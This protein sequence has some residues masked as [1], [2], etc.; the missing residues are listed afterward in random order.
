M[1]TKFQRYSFSRFKISA[2]YFV[3][4]RVLQGFVYFFVTLFMLRVMS[5]S[6]YGAYM[7]LLGFIE[8]M[9][10]LTSF[11]LFE[12]IRRYLPE[13][14]EKGSKKELSSFYVKIIITR[15]FVLSILGVIIYIAWF[16]ICDWLNYT[17]EHRRLYVFAI[18]YI[19]I[20]LMFRFIVETLECL[21]EQK[22]SQIIRILFPLGQLACLVAIYI[23]S[24]SLTF[25]D[26]VKIS[27]LIV[28]LCLIISLIY[29]KKQI[30][31]QDQIGNVNINYSEV[32]M[33]AWHISGANI[34]QTFASFGLMR[35]IVSNQLGLEVAGVFGFL[36]Q[37]SNIVSRYLP[38]NFLI[39]VIRPMLVS[40]YTINRDLNLLNHGV[41][42][43]W[44]SNIIIVS[45]YLLIT[46]IIG[47][48][49]IRTLSDGQISGAG[50]IL[51]L[52]FFLLFTTS[53]RQLIEMSLQILGRT[54]EIRSLSFLLLLMPVFVWIGTG[55][56]LIGVVLSMVAFSWLWNVI[57]LNKITKWDEC[58]ELDWNSLIRIVVG[59]ASIFIII[60]L[61]EQYVN[62]IILV[63]LVLC[64][65]LIL[66][67][68]SKPI[69]RDEYVLLEKILGSK[70]INYIKSL[71]KFS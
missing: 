36:Q 3:Y 24:D 8:T 15:T 30:S 60:S 63:I 10:P 58:I 59:V 52:M 12:V 49:I 50:Q 41:N 33:F 1:N 22:Y 35:L 69:N 42:I 9:V 37:L 56:D 47:D 38:S 25:S 28:S 40:R 19:L 62:S 46:Y 21:M 51:T 17:L 32:K 54:K 43:M 5:P 66:I 11:G 53:Q 34:L 2:K 70:K 65:Y 7:A 39:N 45:V 67:I 14:A 26:A 13:L 71:V 4:G 44:K 57:M 68:T 61:T 23:I 16:Q 64:L 20:T 18:A 27:L 31:K 55:Y 48:Q 29:T 6:D